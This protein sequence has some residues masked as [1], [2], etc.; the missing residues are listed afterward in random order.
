MQ[1]SAQR[2]TRAED[3]DSAIDRLSCKLSD[4]SMDSLHAINY[5]LN[6]CFDAE[7]VERLKEQSDRYNVGANLCGKYSLGILNLEEF[8]ERMVQ[9]DLKCFLCDIEEYL[10]K[11]IIEKYRLNQSDDDEEA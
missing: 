9:T 6:F 1:Y 3:I 11:K 8:C 7:Q 5:D 4:L 10:P 2:W